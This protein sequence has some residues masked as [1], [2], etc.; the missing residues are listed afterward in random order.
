M[1]SLTIIF[2]VDFQVLLYNKLY[3]L[4]QD[5]PWNDGGL[6]ALVSALARALG[7]SR[8]PLAVFP[9]SMLMSLRS[10]ETP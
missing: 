5:I 2:I 3:R 4:L 9:C 7:A 1:I 10:S 6:G 8:F